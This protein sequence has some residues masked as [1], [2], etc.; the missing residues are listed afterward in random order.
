VVKRVLECLHDYLHKLLRQQ[1]VINSEGVLDNPHCFRDVFLRWQRQGLEDAG[2][3]YF[4]KLLREDHSFGL[5][6]FHH[7]GQ[8]VSGN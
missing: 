1:I 8:L 4:G 5:N 6:R 3:Q 2:E 7:C